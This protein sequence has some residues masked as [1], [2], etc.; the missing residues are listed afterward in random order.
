MYAFPFGL[1]IHLNK[2]NLLSPSTRI[3]KTDSRPAIMWLSSGDYL[4]HNV[5]HIKNNKIEAS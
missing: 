3:S 1:V 2:R 4:L 5:T